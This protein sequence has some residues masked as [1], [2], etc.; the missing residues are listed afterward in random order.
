M[1]NVGDRVTDET[2]NN[3]G[4][5]TVVYYT[6]GLYGVRFDSGTFI[7]H[8]KEIAKVPLSINTALFNVGDRVIYKGSA[9]AA[10]WGEGTI[11]S[12]SGGCY[13]VQFDNDTSRFIFFEDELVSTASSSFKFEVGDRVTDKT[14]LIPGYGTIVSVG[15]DGLWSVNFDSTWRMP[16]ISLSKTGTTPVTPPP[17]A[18]KVCSHSFKQYIG[19][20]QSFD[21][22]V[23]CDTKRAVAK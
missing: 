5:G 2:P 14:G 23:H 6:K 15:S 4:V 22:C 8:H 18:A 3:L 20:T 1:V 17:P 21:Y 7:R 19:L 16:S 12:I 10:G 9:A 11:H 13:E